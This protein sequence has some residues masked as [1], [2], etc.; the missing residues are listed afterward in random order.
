M[1]TGEGHYYSAE[2]NLIVQSF[3]SIAS[4]IW[5]QLNTYTNNLINSLNN[6]T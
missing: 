6:E 4:L 3:M 2:L 1:S 5:Q